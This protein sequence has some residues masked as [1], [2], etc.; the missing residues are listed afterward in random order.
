MGIALSGN[1]VEF[2]SRRD[3]IPV[4]VVLVFYQSVTGKTLL[5][6]NKPDCLYWITLRFTRLSKRLSFSVSI[7]QSNWAVFACALCY[8]LCQTSQI[9]S[10]MVDFLF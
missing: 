2:L 3:K 7:T 8:L 5:S 10:K 4:H 1:Y 6:I 9:C